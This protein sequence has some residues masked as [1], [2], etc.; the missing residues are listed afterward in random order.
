MVQ[1]HTSRKRE[2]IK[3]EQKESNQGDNVL[4][5]DEVL[6]D[7]LKSCLNSLHCYLVHG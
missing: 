2:E 6:I 1:N 5:G 4:N 7:I 3:L